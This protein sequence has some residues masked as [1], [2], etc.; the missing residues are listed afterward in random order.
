MLTKPNTTL[1]G[2]YAD[3]NLWCT[4][5]RFATTNEVAVL[6]NGALSGLRIVNCNRSPNA[7]ISMMLDFDLKKVDQQKMNFF[8]QELEQF[9]RERPLTF[10]T[11][12][13]FRC[14]HIDT[15]KELIQYSVRVRHMRSWQDAAVVLHSRGELLWFSI[16]LGNELGIN[17]AQ[18]PIQVA[19]IC[20]A[21]TS[22]E[23]AD[24]ADIIAAIGGGTTKAAEM[25]VS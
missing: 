15:N 6:N 8:Q 21:T 7:L 9:I 1:H 3:I 25:A 19:T 10:D 4:T 24:A 20:D 18:L 22:I 17:K 2:H 23:V 5:L 11:L 13:F 16:K 12:I 14:E